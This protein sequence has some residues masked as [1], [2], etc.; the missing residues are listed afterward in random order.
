R[1]LDLPPLGGAEGEVASAMALSFVRYLIDR[2]G[3]PTFQRLLAE[4]APHRVDATA[5]ELYGESV[6]AL[7]E[8]WLQKLQAGAPDLKASRFVRLSLQYLR[9]HRRREVEIFVYMLL[10]LG[11]TMVFPFAIRRLFDD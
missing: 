7:E 8:S 5:Q 1:E 9:P 2:G 11:F 4:S 3:S 6:A 10:G